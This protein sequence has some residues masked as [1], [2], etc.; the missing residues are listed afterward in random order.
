MYKGVSIRKK[1]FLTDFPTSLTTPATE[2]LLISIGP[3]LS[4]SYYA[5]YV[6]FHSFFSYKKPHDKNS[7]FILIME[8]I[9][10][11]KRLDNLT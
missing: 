3:L 4:V 1:P 8:P 5:K 2:N 11:I 9:N 10:P 7:I 6:C